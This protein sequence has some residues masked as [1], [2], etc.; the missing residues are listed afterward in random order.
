MV[1]YSVMGSGG[2]MWRVCVIV[3]DRVTGSECVFGSDCNM[4]SNCGVGS[5]CMIWSNCGN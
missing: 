2:V 4:G 3:C 1:C 5:N